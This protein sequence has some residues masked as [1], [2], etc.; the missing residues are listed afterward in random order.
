MRRR[1]DAVISLE[2]TRPESGHRVSRRRRQAMRKLLHSLRMRS[3]AAL[4]AVILLAAALFAIVL[5]GSSTAQQAQRPAFVIVERVATTGPESIQQDYAKLAREILPKY[6]ARYLARSQRNALLEG[7]GDAPCC[8]AILQFPT[9]DAVR[10][11][12]DSP[13]NRE[14][15]KIRQNG[16]KFRLIAIDGLPVQ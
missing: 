9:M 8:M 14:A 15:A 16:A 3:G 11:W 1:E 13:E 6:G 10:R 5:A 12:Y 7:D 2:Q 4:G